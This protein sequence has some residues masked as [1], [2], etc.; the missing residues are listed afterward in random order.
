MAC[1]EHEKLT[2]A[3]AI[4]ALLDRAFGEGREQKTAQRLRDGNRPAIALIAR[5][6]AGAVIGTLR[7]W[8]VAIGERRGALLLGPL[9]VDEAR[10][11][12]RIGARLMRRALAEASF[13][14]WGSVI[15]VGDAPYY[16]RFGF[17]TAPTAAMQLPGPVDRVRFLALE[18]R[19]GALAGAQGLVQADLPVPADAKVVALRKRRAPRRAAASQRGEMALAR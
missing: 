15:L 1:L 12:E 8:P 9:A 5:D 14:G 19:P 2:D 11:C 7:L 16:E 10:R 17:H 13:T 3:G 4:E 18:L 6:E